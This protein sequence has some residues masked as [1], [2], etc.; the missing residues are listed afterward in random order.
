LTQNV[1]VGYLHGPTV[2]Q[3]FHHCL[4][5]LHIH[6]TYAVAR[7][8]EQKV[9]RYCGKYGGVNVCRLR[10]ELVS[11][12]LADERCDWLW[13]LDQDATFRP[14]MLDCLLEVADP[15]E[16]PIVGAL[17]HQYRGVTDDEFQ[18]VFGPSGLQQ[19]ELLP[20]MYRTEWGPAGEWVGYREVTRYEP[21][22]QEVDATGCHCLL[23]HRTVFE[24]IESEHPY[25]WFR[26]DEIA[27]GTIA[28]EDIWF[29][30]E[31]KRAGFPIYVNTCLESGHVKPVI[32]THELSNVERMP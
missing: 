8:S 30:L 14:D 10:N 4:F 16:R 26:E 13:M 21:G 6:D 3:E 28:G 32:L 19:R 24:A 31:A 22:L 23:V 18:P 5:N 7:G 11:D 25:R 29:C 12:F 20:T 27:P 15:S 9:R 17:A 1:L 2:T